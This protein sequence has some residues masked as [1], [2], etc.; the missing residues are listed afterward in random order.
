MAALT[1]RNKEKEEQVKRENSEMDAQLRR[2]NK[3]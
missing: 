3:Q 2:E 1:T